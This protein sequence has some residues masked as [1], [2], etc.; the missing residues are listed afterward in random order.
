[1][2]IITIPGDPVAQQRPRFSRRLGRAFNPQADVDN[3]ITWHIASQWGG[4]EPLD[5]PVELDITFHMKLP[6]STSKKKRASLQG[7]P[8]LKKKD[9]DNLIK[10]YL[11]CAN[12][13]LFH[14]DGQVWSITA[15]KVWDVEGKTVVVIR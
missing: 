11:D 8:C 12:G 6:A 13:I 2:I 9:L 3:C 5:G 4:R 1:M 7:Q 14:D 15:R 10:K